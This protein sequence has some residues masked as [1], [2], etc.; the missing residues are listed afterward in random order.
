[1]GR[2]RDREDREYME[3]R[4]EERVVAESPRVAVVGEDRVRIEF[5]IDD[6]LTQLMKQGPPELGISVE[7]CAGCKGCAA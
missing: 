5:R 7:S 3:E 6:L 2:G 1:M 4:D